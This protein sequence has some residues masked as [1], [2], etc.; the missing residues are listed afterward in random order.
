[1]YEQDPTAEN[2]LTQIF[3]A[4]RRN[5]H[6]RETMAKLAKTQNFSRETLRKVEKVDNTAP[7][8]IKDAMGKVISIHK[9]Y[10]FNKYL[11][12]MPEEERDAIAVWLLQ[13]EIGNRTTGASK[14]RAIV[15]NLSDVMTIARRYEKILTGESVDLYLKHNPVGLSQLAEMLDDEIFRLSRFKLIIQKRILNRA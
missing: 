1:M 8:I 15:K 9:A 6:D 13:K 2:E 12:S 11:Q 3:G 14:E 7:Q 10:A 5:R 4:A